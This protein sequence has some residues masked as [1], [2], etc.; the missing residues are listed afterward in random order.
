VFISSHVPCHKFLEDVHE[1]S[2]HIQS[3]LASSCATVQTGLLRRPYTPQC[4]EASVLKTSGCQGNTVRTL[5]QASP[6]S[7]RSW[8][9]ID[10]Y[11][12]S[13]YKTSGR[14]GNLSGRYPA[15][16][17]ILGFLY[18]RR[19]ELQRRPSGCMAKPSECGPV[20]GRIV[21]FWKDGRRRLSRRGYLPSGRS[22]TRVR[23]CV[24]LGFLKPIYRG[25]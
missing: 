24:A 21:L 25:L 18:E 22:I 5:G 6:I 23:I 16:Q 7:T 17:N 1:D 8:F 12:G 13:F 3:Q 4:L 20:L 15:F 9:S 19:K 14:R 2:M 11:L 10:T